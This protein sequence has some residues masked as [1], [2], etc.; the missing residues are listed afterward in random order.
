[1]PTLNPYLTF[2]G[3]CAEAMQ[4]YERA[5][6][7]KLEMLLRYSETPTAMQNSPGGDRI[8]HAHL[9]IDGSDVMGCDAMTDQ[10]YQAMQGI[11]LTLNYPTA[12]EARRA[13]EALSPGGKVGAPLQE[14]FWAEAWGTVT[15]RFGTPWM[16][17][18]AMKNPG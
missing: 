5:L 6:G 11:T 14:T 18:G 3:N 4:F 9:V 1:M 12:A 13:F 7:A 16:V 17:N 10:P 15:D 2:D 8:A